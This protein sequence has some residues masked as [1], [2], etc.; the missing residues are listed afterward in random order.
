VVHDL[1]GVVREPLPDPGVGPL[2]LGAKLRNAF[3]FASSYLPDAADPLLTDYLDYGP[4]LSRDFKAL[5]V[6]SALLTFGADAFR[7]ALSGTLELAQYL[8]SRLAAVPG[9]ELAAPVTLTAVCFRMP[10]ADHRVHHQAV[11]DALAE[12]G[13]A[14]LGPAVVDGRP[15]IRACLANY[16]TTRDDIDLIVARLAAM[17]TCGWG[18][19]RSPAR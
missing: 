11:I 12:D 9:I 5:K 17:S 6:W 2:A 3:A 14:L 10:E 7:A 18:A 13:T 4:Q 8:A 19:P 16:R 15:A 1:I